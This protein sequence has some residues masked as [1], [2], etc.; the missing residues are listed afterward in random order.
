ML[1]T[2]LPHSADSALPAVKEAGAVTA[3]MAQLRELPTDLDRFLY[4]RRSQQ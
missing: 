2:I 1:Q 3:S 4:L